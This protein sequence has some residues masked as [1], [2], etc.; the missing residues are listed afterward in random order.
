MAGQIAALKSGEFGRFNGVSIPKPA[1][2]EVNYV[3]ILERAEFFLTMPA[4]EYQNAWQVCSE[5]RMTRPASIGDL[6]QVS[7][8]WHQAISGAE[9]LVRGP[10]T[11]DG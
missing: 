1:P 5:G 6:K 11:K 7:T 4:V 10:R 8:C 3:E 2:R 9:C